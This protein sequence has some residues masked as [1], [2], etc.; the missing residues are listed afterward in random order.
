MLGRSV[1]KYL[2][3]S[4][5]KMRLV[6]DTVRNLEVESALGIL[7]NLNKGAGLSVQ[8][9]IRSAVESARRKPEGKATPL[10]ISRIMADEG[11]TRTARRFRPASMGRGVRI[12]KRQS[13]LL[14]EVD[15]ASTR[16][17]QLAR[18]NANKSVMGGEKA[19]RPDSKAGQR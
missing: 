10:Y 3:V 18:I 15:A 17:P 16:Q 5:R 4:P 9:A 2:K 11:P 19:N 8:K 1:T 13:H 6:I 7:Q 14:V 12:R